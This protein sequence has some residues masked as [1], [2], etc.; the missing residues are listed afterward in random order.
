MW[1]LVRGLQ[2]E[3]LHDF[4]AS[5]IF[6]GVTESR[7]MRWAGLRARIGEMRNACRILVRRPEGESAVGELG[8]DGR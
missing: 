4:Y 8:V 2:I 6:I 3:E 7:R 1:K 5:R